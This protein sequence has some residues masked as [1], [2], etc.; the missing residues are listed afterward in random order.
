MFAVTEQLRIMV[1][2]KQRIMWAS[3]KHKRAYTLSEYN[4]AKIDLE[5]EMIFVTQGP[6]PEFRK[7]ARPADDSILYSVDYNEK[8]AYINQSTYDLYEHDRD[9]C[10]GDS[11]IEGIIQQR[12]KI[13]RTFARGIREE[14][15]EIAYERARVK[16]LAVQL[17]RESDAREYARKV[18]VRYQNDLADAKRMVAAYN[19]KRYG[20]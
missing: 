19:K 11:W 9:D 7:F 3:K 12:K 1:Y 8:L 15:E 13:I 5:L 20:K 6:S 18:E 14:N 16:A 4:Q 2:D 10:Q 17:Q